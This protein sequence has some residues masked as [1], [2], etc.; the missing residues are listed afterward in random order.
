MIICEST[1]LKYFQFE[2]FADENVSQAVFTR[3][4]GVSPRPWDS[5]NLGS[6]VG[7]DLSR[8]AENKLKVLES[9]GF[10]ESRLVQIHQ[11]HI[12]DW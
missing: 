7:D 6:T 1:G 11:V 5:L 4:G 8:V 2:S 9:I 3:L 12:K 10:S